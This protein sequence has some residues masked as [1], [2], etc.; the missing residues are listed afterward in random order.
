MTILETSCP[1]YTDKKNA[2]DT[3]PEQALTLKQRV[4]NAIDMTNIRKIT[5]S[6]LI[7]TVLV[8]QTP[9]IQATLI[10]I[11]HFKGLTAIIHSWATA[12]IIEAVIIVLVLN[13]KLTAAL[14]MMLVSSLFV[15]GFYFN[16]GF[17]V[18]NFTSVGIC[19]FSLGLPFGT[20][21]LLS[22]MIAEA[23]DKTEVKEKT[24]DKT[25]PDKE[26]ETKMKVVKTRQTGLS[27]ET[28]NWI[29]RLRQDESL[30]LR[31]IQEQTGIGKDRV[32]R[33]LK[34]G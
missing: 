4:P 18:L 10:E 29:K 7:L 14:V 16:E 21:T 9:H 33:I 1:R 8:V 34:E 23:E 2:Q 13:K 5:I 6:T 27:D 31:Q 20:K 19:L 12:F 30:S 28:V 17:E 3:T 26:P 15:L 25:V 11:S 22:D 32:S 24:E